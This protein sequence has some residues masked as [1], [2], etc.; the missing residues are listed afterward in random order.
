[1][2]TSSKYW[3]P[4]KKYGWGWG[5]PITWQGWT[6]TVSYFVVIVAGA[7]LLDPSR[8][9]ILYL[10]LVALATGGILIICWAKGEPPSWRWGS[11]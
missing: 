9:M 7:L 5:F 6:V 4:A 3:F 2:R 10:L 8:N 1:M 11:K